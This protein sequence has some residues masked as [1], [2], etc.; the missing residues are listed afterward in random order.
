VGVV[1]HVV[2]DE[3]T[4]ARGGLRV[5]R[6][7]AI[8][9]LSVQSCMRRLLGKVEGCRVVLAFAER[10]G[11]VLLDRV[12]IKVVARPSSGNDDMNKK[13]RKKGNVVL[14]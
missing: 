5:I 6:L 10:A 3:I 1:E 9:R 12:T 13:K 4:V 14:I 8:V 7:K 11:D 2:G